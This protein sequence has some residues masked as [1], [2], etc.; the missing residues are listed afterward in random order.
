MPHEESP[1][2]SRPLDCSASEVG[3]HTLRL[4][5]E[6][7]IYSKGII[8]SA[9][10]WA[11]LVALG[12]AWMVTSISI[13]GVIPVQPLFRRNVAAGTAI[14]TLVK[15][16]WLDHHKRTNRKYDPC[17]QMDFFSTDTPLS[18]QCRRSGA[19]SRGTCRRISSVHVREWKNAAT[20]A[21]ERGTSSGREICR[22]VGRGLGDGLFRKGLTSPL[23]LPR[24]R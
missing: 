2:P 3:G 16:T 8:I 12:V 20:S 21:N 4:A 18:N 23:I 15:K 5:T 13:L 6:G 7:D 14:T 17:L 1:S 24:R 11:N 10:I 22:K 9:P 19:V